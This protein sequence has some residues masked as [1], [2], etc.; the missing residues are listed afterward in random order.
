[1][2]T[3]G[4]VVESVAVTD[5]AGMTPLFVSGKFKVLHSLGSSKLFPFVTTVDPLS[6]GIG[7]IQK[8]CVTVAPLDTTIPPIG[9]AP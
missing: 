8:F 7:T 5:S 1:M 2:V 3:P 9:E 4:V 6:A